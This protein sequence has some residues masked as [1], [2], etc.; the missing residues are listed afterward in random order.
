M[1]TKTETVSKS[2]SIRSQLK[3][4]KPSE[5]SPKAVVEALKA[6]GISVNPGLVSLIK[7]KMNNKTKRKAKVAKRRTSARASKAWKTRWKGWGE[8]LNGGKMEN[9]VLAKDFL[10]S[11]GGIEHAKRILDVVNKLVS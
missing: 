6:K 10:N 8:F 2:E 3:S 5:R 7:S 11:T 9:L 4:M 1:A